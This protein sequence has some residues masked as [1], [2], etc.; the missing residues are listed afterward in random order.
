L[1][2]H[3]LYQET[4]KDAIAEAKRATQAGWFTF[5]MG[6]G[7][8]NLVNIEGSPL[9]LVVEE[10]KGRL[11]RVLYGSRKMTGTE[12]DA[13][14]KLHPRCQKMY[15]LLAA[16]K[17]KTDRASL[18]RTFADKECGIQVGASTLDLMVYDTTA[19]EAHL[20]R[21]PSYGVKWKTFR[22][23]KE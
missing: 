23:E 21:G 15:D 20:S 1:L 6:D 3:L 16:A 14:V 13:T 17:G 19:R 9:G 10:H 18:Q 2:T 4:L 12:P 22:F 7:R 5:V 8:G 11:A